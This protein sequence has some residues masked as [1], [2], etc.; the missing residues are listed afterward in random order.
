MWVPIAEFPN[1]AI[2]KDGDVRNSLTGKILKPRKVSGGRYYGVALVYKGQRKE[3]KIHQ[4]LGRYFVPNP[5]NG[6]SLDHI[7]RNGLDNRLEN[8][9]WVSMAENQQNRRSSKLT[10][11]DMRAIKDLYE[12]GRYTKQELGRLFNVSR[13]RIV[14]LTRR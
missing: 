7:N 6:T 13:T 2:N 12:T 4:L 10:A 14:Q 5:N 11:A 3:F 1:Y 9:R 8:L